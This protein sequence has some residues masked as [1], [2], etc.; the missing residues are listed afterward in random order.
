MR[1][2]EV[3]GRL[4]RTPRELKAELLRLDTQLHNLRRI[5][6]E[7][8]YA[9]GGPEGLPPTPVYDAW[10]AVHSAIAAVEELRSRVEANPR[11]IP[12]GEA[13]TWALVKDNID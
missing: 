12:P 10:N 13:G 3:T 9:F 2:C 6:A 7:F 1:R 5:E 11:P 4:H 8:Q